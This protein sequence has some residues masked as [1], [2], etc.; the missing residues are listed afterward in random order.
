MDA[1]LL[2]A[3]LVLGV[4]MSAHG[5]QKLFGWFGGYGLNGT[6]GFLEALGFRPGRL[7]VTA[8]SAA[9]ITGGLLLAAGFLSPVASG[10][11]VSV[12]IVAAV[13]VHWEHGVFASNNG[14]E[15]PLLYGTGAVALA[16]T[17]PGAYS[18]DALV[19]LT[20]YWTP[21]VAWSAIAIGAIGGVANLA[22]RRPAA[23][24]ATA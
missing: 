18:L 20:P 17:G 16:L 22:I 13:S 24:P 6:A 3:R 5:A 4:L 9:E 7:F 23:Q 14:I 10:L 19:G 21:V 2:I 15:V 11:I 1:G 12:M 8:A